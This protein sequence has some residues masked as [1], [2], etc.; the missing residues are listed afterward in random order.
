MELSKRAVMRASSDHQ[1]CHCGHQQ[2]G[3]KNENVK[4]ARQNARFSLPPELS[5]E[6]SCSVIYTYLWFDMMT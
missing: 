4:R 5:V 6:E 1:R 2:I 3:E